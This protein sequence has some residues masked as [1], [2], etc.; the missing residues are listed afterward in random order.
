M[1]PKFVTHLKDK[2]VLAWMMNVKLRKYKSKLSCRPSMSDIMTVLRS[3]HFDTKYYRH[4]YHV[5]Y[6]DVTL[7]AY[8]T[9]IGYRMG[10]DP[11]PSF[12]GTAYYCRRPDVKKTGM[13]PLLHYEK[14]GSHE[15]TMP[16]SVSEFE[17]LRI[18]EEEI[19]E[20]E[21]LRKQKKTILLVSHEMSLTGAPRA[22]LNMAVVLKDLGIHVVFASFLP[23]DM[24]KEVRQKGLESR[25][26]MMQCM[27]TLPEYAR[28]VKHYISAFDAIL[29]NTIVAL[30]YVE[31]IKDISITKLCW[32][33]DGSFGFSC[34]PFSSSFTV[35]YPLFDRI[36]VV[37]NYAKA[38][39]CS[40]G[41]GNVEMYNL[42]YGIDDCTNMHGARE[43]E[44][45]EKIVMVLAGTIEKRKG[46][47]I[48][49]DCLKLLSQDTLSSIR[50]YVIGKAVD[51]EISYR[52][53]TERFECVEMIGG[54]LHEELLDMFTKM[55][56]LLCPSLDDPM[57]IVCTEAMMLSKPIIVS[58]HT[59][60]ASLI[61]EGE[62]GFVVQAGN[63]QSLANAIK[64]SVNNKEKLAA[65]GKQAR[66]VFEQYFTNN[67]FRN[68]V[69]ENVI[70]FLD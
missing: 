21:L 67:I 55:D 70:R 59:G 23:G 63:P 17:S 69:K 56:I 41:S 47:D 14:Y 11:S 9:Y 37:G 4:T 36:F 58:D 62:S 5:K 42:M 10:D 26:L 13:N 65:M 61:K 44:Y 39:A 64:I 3:E 48:L 35:L 68:Q 30:P 25:I 33:H 1:L 38:I 57:P 2:I 19:Q 18:V 66:T 31:F 28:M 24:E 34:S 32:I 54:M 49:L 50:I 40:Y 6:D 52:L 29:L 7:A 53:K 46:Q 45:D 43:E 16:M 22:L 8:Y 20:I 27:E 51:R 15:C 60:T 12:S